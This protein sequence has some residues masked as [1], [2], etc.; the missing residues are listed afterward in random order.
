MKVFQFPELQ[1]E[2]AASGQGHIERG[3]HARKQAVDIV[4]VHGDGAAAGHLF[5]HTAVAPPAEIPHEEHA[6]G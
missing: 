5:R 6:K 1:G 2:V 4:A 3:S